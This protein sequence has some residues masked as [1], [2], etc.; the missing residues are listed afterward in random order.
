MQDFDEAFWS[1]YRI[2]EKGT[3]ISLEEFESDKTTNARIREAVRDFVDLVFL[4]V[5]NKFQGEKD[6]ERIIW[7]LMRENVISA[8]LAQEIIDILNLV[9]RLADVDDKVLYGMLVRILEDLEEL[10]FSIKKNINHKT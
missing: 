6:R 10:Y 9:K 4:V 7:E 1:L 3:R 5:E 8:Y 2:I